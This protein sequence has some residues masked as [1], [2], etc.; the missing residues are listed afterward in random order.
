MNEILRSEASVIY[1]FSTIET[2]VTLFFYCL[3]FILGKIKK[4]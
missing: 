2:H 1:N 4:N 3:L